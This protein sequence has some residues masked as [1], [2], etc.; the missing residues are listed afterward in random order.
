MGD[1]AG[2]RPIQCSRRASAGQNQ[3]GEAGIR[4]R[5]PPTGTGCPTRWRPGRY[6]N[7]T[8]LDTFRRT[9]AEYVRKKLG[10]RRSREFDDQLLQE[11][12]AEKR[13][14]RVL[15][16][17]RAPDWLEVQATAIPE[18]LD[19]DTLEEPPPGQHF[20]AGS[21]A[22]CQTDEV[23]DLKVRRAE[24][25]RRSGHNATVRVHDVPT[26]HFIGNFVD[27]DGG[28]LTG[29]RRLRQRPPQCVP[30]VAG[31]GAGAVRHLPHDAARRH[32]LVPSG[33]ELRRHG[34]GLELQQRGRRPSA[35]PARTSSIGDGALRG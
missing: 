29:P 10:A 32:I 4:S 30:A 1:A 35:A 31:Q 34:V 7:P 26:H 28:G 12:V 19:M 22:V 3:L 6:Q 21:F 11:L 23:G 5:R 8:H 14:G 25:W 13:L 15:G 33:H 17:T 2:G 20:L 27:L 18:Q 16:P 24:D 9:N